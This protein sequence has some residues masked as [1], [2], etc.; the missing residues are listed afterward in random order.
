MTV[1]ELIDTTDGSCTL[2]FIVIRENEGRGHWVHGYRIGKDI[3]LL[4]CDQD[5][6]V[7]RMYAKGSAWHG[8]ITLNPGDVIN[9]KRWSLPITTICKAPEKA[10][11]E[12][13]DLEVSHWLARNVPP[14]YGKER[15]ASNDFALDIECFTPDYVPRYHEE[16]K[17]SETE[18]D[19]QMMLTI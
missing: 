7:R 14:F 8:S 12:V 18:D 11:K 15:V 9:H 2:A 16:I 1:R 17:R 10:P 4:P 3:S 6:V 5:G 13:L 19:K